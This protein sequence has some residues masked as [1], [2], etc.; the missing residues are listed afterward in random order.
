MAAT[1]PAAPLAWTAPATQ[2]ERAS[3]YTVNAD[4]THVE[5]QFSRVRVDEPSA[6]RA[7][8]QSSLRYSTSLQTLEVLEAYT[9]TKDG[10]RIDVTPDKIWSCFRRSM[11]AP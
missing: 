8:G 10:Q 3:N 4:A 1:L 7:M 9:T 2:L 11:S 5:E 6:V